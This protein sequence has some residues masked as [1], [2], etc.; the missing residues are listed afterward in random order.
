M[1]EE[2]TVNEDMLRLVSELNFDH[3]KE[4]PL[5]SSKR[6]FGNS[7]YYKDV[8]RITGNF[9]KYTNQYEEISKE[10][11]N[12]VETILEDVSVVLEILVQTQKLETGHYQKE[13]GKWNKVE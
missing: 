9:E 10:G 3:K 8:L 11:Q 1:K 6:P 5:I 4:K 7:D 13:N 12:Y 2:I